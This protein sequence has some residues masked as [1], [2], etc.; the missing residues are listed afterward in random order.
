MMVTG[1]GGEVSFGATGS[2]VVCCWDAGGV[3]SDDV[4]PAPLCAHDMAAA[5]VAIA[6][7]TRVEH[8]L[9][10]IGPPLIKAVSVRRHDRHLNA[11]VRTVI[12][13][14]GSPGAATRLR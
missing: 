1:G 4:G 12:D 13:A 2:P 6:A 9:A 10:R 5:N 11:A 3:L 7:A 14:R 8:T